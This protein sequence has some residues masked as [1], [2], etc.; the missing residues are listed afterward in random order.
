MKIKRIIKELKKYNRDFRI[1][2]KHSSF[3]DNG[4]ELL[5]TPYVNSVA[6][7]VKNNDFIEML[8]RQDNSVFCFYKGNKKVINIY[9]K[10]MFQQ[11]Y[12]AEG[13]LNGGWDTWKNITGDSGP[14]GSY[15]EPDY[16]IVLVLEEL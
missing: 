8:E 15:I 11:T 10:E 7:C 2:A 13:W 5:L 12:P 16:F 14:E 9:C 6:H 1:L 4:Y 3:D